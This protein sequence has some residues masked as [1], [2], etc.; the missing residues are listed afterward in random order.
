MSA[1]VA[2]GLASAGVSLWGGISGR[3]SANDQAKKQK[4]IGKMQGAAIEAETE[5][6][7][8]RMDK[9]NEAIMSQG[10]AAVG[11]SGFAKGSSQDVY[12]SSMATEMKNQRDWTEESGATKAELAVKGANYSADAL[13]SQGKSSMFSGVGGMFT[14]L[15]L[16]GKAK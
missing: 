10:T 15:A 16:A 5:E 14:G 11:A 3:K 1:L 12:M 6:E 4:Q 13:K 8:R 7:L 9:Q 2:Y